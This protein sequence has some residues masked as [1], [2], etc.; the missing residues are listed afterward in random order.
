MLAMD[1]GKR[2]DSHNKSSYD[3]SDCTA[4]IHRAHTKLK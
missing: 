3:Y 2:R 4:V 1:R